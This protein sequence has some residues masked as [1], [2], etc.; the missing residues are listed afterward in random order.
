ML[1]YEYLLLILSIIHLLVDTQPIRIHP[2][3]SININDFVLDYVMNIFPE[4]QC[5]S[6]KT[7]N[8]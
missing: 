8:L 6:F 5:Q 1:K 7:F 4:I 3:N 2:K